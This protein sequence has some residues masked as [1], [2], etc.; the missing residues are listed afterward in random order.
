M[1]TVIAVDAMGGDR[2]PGAA[3]EGAVLAAAR[4]SIGILLVGPEA[5][6]DAELARYDPAARASIRV[7]DAPD[8][9]AMH[10]S[11]LPALRRK[12]RSSIRVAVDAVAAGD[13]AA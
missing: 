3:V 12:R 6:L 2:A 5:I 4:T 11:P 1:S 7:I 10:E 8:V 9:V 13:A